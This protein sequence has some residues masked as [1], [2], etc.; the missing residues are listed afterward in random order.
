MT[1]PNFFLLGA[2]KAGTTT[3]HAWLGQHP[4]VFLPP[5]KEPHFLQYR[6]E[7]G[8]D[9]E[10]AFVRTLE[11]YEKLFAPGAGRRAVGEASTMSLCFREA[12]ERIRELTPDAKLAAVLRQPADRAWSHYHYRVG[13]GRENLRSFEAALAAEPRRIR[14][15]APVGSYYMRVGRYSEQFAVYRELFPAAQLRVWLYDDLIADPPRLM[16]ELFEFLDV[17]PTAPIDMSERRNPTMV[18]KSRNFDAAMRHQGPL[19]R[20]ASKLLPSGVKRRLRKLH[21]T[22]REPAPKM[23]AE[24][25]ARLTEQ[26]REDIVRLQE[27]LGRDLTGWM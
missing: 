8:I 24:L 13:L 25:R 18:P 11:E 1:L 4:E 22:E 21:R 20:V 16:R 27:M 2:P 9:R 14:E 10:I 19:R 7:G 23:P 12:A 6:G 5:L 26:C 17:D 15:G 3:L